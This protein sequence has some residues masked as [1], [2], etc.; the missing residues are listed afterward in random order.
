MVPLRNIRQY[1]RDLARRFN[2]ERVI[3]FGSYAKGT[4]HEDSD[5]DMAIIFDSL[6]DVFDTQVELL[7]LRRQFDI[8]IEPHPFIE[9][10]FNLSH[11]LAKEI[12]NH[13]VEIA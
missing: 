7:K 5:I 2:P 1:A 9:S 10:N 8:R 13:G 6:Y 12:L 11:P 3:L 4:S